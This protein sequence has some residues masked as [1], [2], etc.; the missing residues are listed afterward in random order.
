[1]L[2]KYSCTR[3][4]R[5]VAASARDLLGGNGILLQNRVARHFAD[6]EALHTY[7]GTESVQA[8]IVG[9]DVTGV[10]ASVW[11]PPGRT[12]ALHTPAP[13]AP[14]RGA[15]ASLSPRPAFSR[16]E[17]HEHR[18]PSRRRSRHRRGRGHPGP[19][20]RRAH[21][22]RALPRGARLAL[23]SRA[24]RARDP[25]RARGRGRRAGAG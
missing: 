7:E 3:G 15:G 1:S 20:A 10:A 19:P 11:P 16:T 14:P 25:G 24:R 5:E 8:L 12:P 18:H 4:A 21:P 13:L 6:I 22:V 9:R 2:A 17:H 23:G